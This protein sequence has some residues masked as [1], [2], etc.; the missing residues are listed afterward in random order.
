VTSTSAGW[1]PIGQTLTY[2]AN[3]GNKEFVVTTPSDLSSFLTP[4]QKIM[5]ARGTAPPTQSMAFTAASSQYATKS[6]PTGITF[7]SAF[8]CE[9]WVYLTGYTGN[10]QA[11]ISRTD[12]STGGFLLYI[13]SSGQVAIQYNNATTFTPFTSYQSVPL[14][15]WVHVAGVV[16]SVSS[17]TGAIYIN[18]VSVPL[19]VGGSGATTLVQTGNLS[20][21]AFNAGIASTFLNGYISEV[22]VW[23]VAQS[24]ANIQANMAISLTGSESNLVALF[25]GNGNFNDKTSNANN[26]TATNGAIATQAANPYNS[27]EYGI[28]TKVTSTQLTIFTGDQNNIPNMT[29]NSPYY[30]TVRAPQ[31]FPAGRENWRVKALL[32][33]YYSQASPVNG[34][35]YNLGSLQLS[36]PTGEWVAWYEG[37]LYILNST[38]GPSAFSTLSTANNSESDTEMTVRPVYIGVTTTNQAGMGNAYRVRG[39]SNT[40]ATTYYL[41]VK[42]DTAGAATLGWGPSSEPTI[43]EAECAYI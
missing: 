39:Y 23:S 41:N 12:D 35:W 17:K 20:V 13:N 21:G 34:T 15:R 42:T 18:G 8:T 40:S 26:L 37:S 31:G 38:N 19:S 30:S 5:F 28:I 32:R 6:S 29:L 22:R 9:A 11:I 27:T 4:G 7:T 43:I 36:I 3:N 10:I 25:Q 2:S 1:N 33:S 24:Q 16:T 14:N